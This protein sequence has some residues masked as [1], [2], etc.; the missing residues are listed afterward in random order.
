MTDRLRNPSSG[1]VDTQG[2]LHFL[3]SCDVELSTGRATLQV[4]RE[5]WDLEYQQVLP[6]LQIRVAAEARDFRAH[7]E[8]ASEQMQRIFPDDDLQRPSLDNKAPAGAEAGPGL[9][10]TWAQTKRNLQHTQNEIAELLAKITTR[11]DLLNDQFA[12]QMQG[13]QNQKQRHIKRQVCFLDF[14][15]TL[16]L[17]A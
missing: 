17:A 10:L 3:V 16:F 4:D 14:R 9:P 2:G 12:A 11:E 7:L 13:Y 15:A 1:T 6:H 8:A 5:Q